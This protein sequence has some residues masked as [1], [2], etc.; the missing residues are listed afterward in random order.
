MKFGLVASLILA[1]SV[2][3]YSAANEA[4][5]LIGTWLFDAMEFRNE[6]GNWE[7]LDHP[8]VGIN[9]LGYISYDSAGYMSVQ[10]VNREFPGSNDHYVA[11]FGTYEVLENENVVVHHTVGNLLGEP[12]SDQRRAYSFKGSTLTLM[13]DETTRLRWRKP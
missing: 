13:P 6:S 4:D 1:L 3:T 10:L 8:V 9:P 2:H 11:Y 7:A 12:G 5:N